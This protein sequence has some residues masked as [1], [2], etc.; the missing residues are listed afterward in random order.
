M[1]KHEYKALFSPCARSIKSLKASAVKVKTSQNLSHIESLN[2]VAREIGYG[3]WSELANQPKNSKRDDFFRAT[4][5]KAGRNLAQKALYQNYL[6]DKNMSDSKDSYR[7]FAVHLWDGFEN[8]GMDN[9]DIGDEILTP[10]SFKQV[11]NKQM[12]ELGESGLLPQNM[13]DQI[14]KTLIGANR[15]IFQEVYENIADKVKLSYAEVVTDIVLILSGQK[16][17]SM[18]DELIINRLET[19]S[20][21]A[22]LE[23]M[24]RNTGLS[25]EQP[26]LDSIFKKDASIAFSLPSEFKS[27]YVFN[28]T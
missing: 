5:E 26:D 12:Q 7:T 25:I 27:K 14:L 23:F 13:P 1:K 24:S 2:Y 20:I 15:I 21:I 16:L 28:K 8:L 18:E 19:L 11:I 6:R 4:Y 17:S 22:E 10:H 3:G 9:V